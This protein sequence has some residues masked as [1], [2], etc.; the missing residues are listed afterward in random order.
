MLNHPNRTLFLSSLTCVMVMLQGIWSFAGTLDAIEHNDS[1]Q[2]DPTVTVHPREIKDVLYNPGMG[3]ADFHFGFEHPPSFDQY[4][5]QTVAYFRWSWADLEPEEGK[6]AFDF[7][8]RIIS[9]AKAR[10]ETLAFRI[11]TEY[12]AGSPPWLHHEGVG[13]VPVGGGVFPDYNNPTFLMYHEKLIKAF[14]ERYA[15]SPDIDHVDIGSV[16][17]W[18]EWNMACCQGVEAQC[19]QYFPVEENQIKITDWYL[20]YFSGTPLVML[21]GGQLKYAVSH[22]AGWRGDCFGDYGYFGPTWNH[23]E[24]AYAS[25]LQD[26]VI[27]RAWMNAPVQFEVCGVMQDWYEKDFDIDLILKKGLEWHV[28]VLNAK[29]SPIP[30]EWRPRVDEF[31]TRIGY[32]FVLRQMTHATEAQ[33]C[34]KLSLRSLWENVGV[35]PIYHDWPL[36]YRLRSAEDHVVAQWA[37]AAHL[38]QWLPGIQQEVED[39]VILPED[40]LEGSYVLDIAIL[41]QRGHAPFV[42]LAISGKRQDGWY[43]I[44]TVSI[45]R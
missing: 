32:R 17:C 24:H 25:V 8:D 45:R 22:G 11:V 37:S 38:R 10:G 6:Y 33:P 7:V 34:R 30:T 13:S 31:L 14:G 1:T 21:H 41:D 44:S 42:D 2:T 43:P 39:A 23:M 20:Q 3:L 29:S 16:G 27:E 18:G 26:P 15:G 9:Q 12:K 36:A 28:S 19:R 35:A 40:A 4:P 5:R